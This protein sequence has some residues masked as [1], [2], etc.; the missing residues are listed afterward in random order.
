MGARRAEAVVVRTPV[1]LDAGVVGMPVVVLA[2]MVMVM[3]MVVAMVMLVVGRVP[4][5]VR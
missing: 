1:G 5:P 2:V 4:V 3:V